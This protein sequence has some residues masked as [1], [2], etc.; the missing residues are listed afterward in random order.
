MPVVPSSQAI[1]VLPVGSAVEIG[2]GETLCVRRSSGVVACVNREDFLSPVPPL[3]LHDMPLIDDA[4]QITTGPSYAC[5]L[6]R[7]RTVW[8]WNTYPTTESPMQISGLTAVVE[9][10]GGSIGCARVLSGEVFCW[11]LGFRRDPFRAAGVSD[12]VELRVDRSDGS[13]CARRAAGNVVCWEV[14]RNPTEVVTPHD[15]EI[16]PMN[17]LVCTHVG[18][19]PINCVSRRRGELFGPGRYP[20]TEEPFS[21][22]G[23]TRLASVPSSTCAIIDMGRVVCW[24]YQYGLGVDLPAEL[25]VPFNVPMEALF[26]GARVTCGRRPTGEMICV[27]QALESFDESRNHDPRGRTAR[28][29]S[30]ARDATSIAWRH[31]NTPCVI[32][33]PGGAICD[34]TPV[35]GLSDAVELATTYWDS[36]TWICARRRGGAV[37]CWDGESV[38]RP[39]QDLPNFTD[40]VQIAGSCVRRATGT[41]SCWSRYSRW[42]RRVSNVA[43]AI[44]IDVGIRTT[45]RRNLGCALQATGHVA[46][47]DWAEDGSVG[48]P[49]VA[50]DV[51]VFEDAVDIAVASLRGGRFACV[52]RRSGGVACFGDGPPT[53]L[54]VHDAVGLVGGLEHLCVLRADGSAYCVGSDDRGQLGGSMFY[55]ITGPVR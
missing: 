11:E 32:R 33:S 30:V 49:L 29:V 48:A 31:D 54:A 9:I 52:R 15:I 45:G 16:A 8:C 12:A 55:G 28:V 19:G 27:G 26:L 22:P 1:E 47:W 39:E 23:L 51:A 14:G 44:D 42:Q 10:R 4:L 50:R 38:L 2:V 17:G 13:F 3:R 21:L 36:S 6:R 18:D 41:V 34:G 20:N 7:D 46:C 53:S 43:D 35:V 37:R 40:A 5:A 25:R 24:G